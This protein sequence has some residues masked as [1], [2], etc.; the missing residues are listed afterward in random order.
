MSVSRT[1]PSLA[2]CLLAAFVAAPAVAASS[3]SLAGDFS[4]TTNP[5]GAWSFTQGSTALG[6]FLPSTPSAV[7]AEGYWGVGTSLAAC[8]AV[9]V[10]SNVIRSM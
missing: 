9:T 1:L 8:T 7:L 10:L 5:N 2:L 4:Q 6:R 3:Y